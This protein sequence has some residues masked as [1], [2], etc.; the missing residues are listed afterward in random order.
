MIDHLLSLSTW[1]GCSVAMF[2]TAV[3]GLV[4]YFVFYKLISKY[5]LEGMRNPT[6]ILFRAVTVLVS[7]MLA[8]AF[9]EVLVE[10]R[11]VRSSVQRETAAISDIFSVLKLFDIERTREIRTIL[12]D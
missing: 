7:L 8:L 2:F 6:S 3:E 4:I 11:K 12:V 9:S 10:I 5:N 1:A